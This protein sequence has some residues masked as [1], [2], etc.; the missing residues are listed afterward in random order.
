MTARVRRVR[1]DGTS[2]QVIVVRD[3]ELHVDA[4]SPAVTD[5]PDDVVDAL[6]AWLQEAR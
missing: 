2:W 3:H 5:L 6:R 4:F 1:Y